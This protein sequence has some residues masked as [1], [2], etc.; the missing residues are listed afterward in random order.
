MPLNKLEKLKKNSSQTRVFG[1]KDEEAPAR[2]ESTY[3]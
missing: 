3:S 1:N 2:R